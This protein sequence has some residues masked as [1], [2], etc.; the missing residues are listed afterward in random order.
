MITSSSLVPLALAIPY[1]RA[2]PRAHRDIIDIRPVG[3]ACIGYHQIVTSTPKAFG[4]KVPV[5]GLIWNRIS[6]GFGEPPRLRMRQHAAERIEG[7]RIDIHKGDRPQAAGARANPAHRADLGK[8]TGV[9]VN[10]AKH[11]ALVV[12]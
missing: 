1:R 10:A 4:T 11:A 12:C 6:S 8:N 3:V 5:A 9:D 2:V 7:Q